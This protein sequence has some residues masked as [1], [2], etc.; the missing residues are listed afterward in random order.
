MALKSIAVSS[1]LVQNIL[2]LKKDLEDA[3][4]D[5]K[6]IDFKTSIDV[7]NLHYSYE[8]EI[9]SGKNTFTLNDISLSIPKGTFEKLMDTPLFANLVKCEEA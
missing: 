8:R 2:D 5:K 1:H 4:K 7:Q 6:Y 3:W 9:N